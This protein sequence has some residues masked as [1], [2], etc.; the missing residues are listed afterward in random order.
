MITWKHLLSP[1]SVS[2]QSGRS[3]STSPC[4]ANSFYESDVHRRRNAASPK[5][6]PSSYP[7]KHR[8]C[9]E[10]A[11]PSERN[12]RRQYRSGR[13]GTH[14]RNTRKAP[15]FGA[16]SKNETKRTRHIVVPFGLRML[17]ST[18]YRPEITSPTRYASSTSPV[19][20]REID[21][22][23][24]GHGSAESHRQCTS[25]VEFIL[26][27]DVVLRTFRIQNFGRRCSKGS[28]RAEKQAGSL[29]FNDKMYRGFS[30]FPHN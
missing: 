7:H 9:T 10:A 6:S 4:S 17:S 12:S 29:E 8:R 20:R 23:W 11:C 19:C 15:R 2:N 13:R 22:W 16:A 5:H 28:P 26:R 14:T 21:R 18:R 1:S 27:K 30:Q 25:P 3:S 24:R